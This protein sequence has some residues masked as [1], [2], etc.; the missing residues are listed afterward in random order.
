MIL[1]KFKKINLLVGLDLS[2][3][4]QHLIEYVSAIE[5]LLKPE[6]IVFLHNLKLSE[7]PKSLLT[8]EKINTIAKN[9]KAKITKQI[10]RLEPNY[11]YEISLQ[12]ESFS[13]IAFKKIFKKEH[14]DL[15]LLG[16]K[17]KLEGNGALNQKLMRLVPSS[18][19]LVPE[20]GSLSIEKI[21]SAVDFSTH[22]KTILNWAEY[23][24]NNSFDKKVEYESLYVSKF[25][26]GFFPTMSAKEIQKATDQECKK[27]EKEW[28]SEY[29]NFS[30]LTIEIAG[31]KSTSAI[32][33]N[34]SKQKKADLLL[35]GMQGSTGIIDY[36]LGS[37]ANAVL[38]R[39]TDIA[40]LFVKNSKK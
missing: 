36:F 23:F 14:F 29:K 8:E 10:E 39:P 25:N 7:L 20:T 35:L 4:D 2:E 5:G 38:Q 21:I 11:P 9:L 40:L 15:L 16:N 26:W 34:F 1:Q 6:K 28:E 12:T 19:L 27:R 30:K 18:I 24:K 17:Q 33:L 13:E 37:V 32:L 31:D 22:T 3:M